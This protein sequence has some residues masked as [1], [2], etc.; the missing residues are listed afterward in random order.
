MNLEIVGKTIAAPWSR[1][2]FNGLA[3]I[4]VQSTK[5]PGEIRLTA[6]ADGLKPATTTVQTIAC[7]L[8]PSLP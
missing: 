4:I 2:L 7:P 6:S 1:S 8:P 3:E 5:E